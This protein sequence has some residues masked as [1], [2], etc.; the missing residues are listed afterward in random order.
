MSV[1]SLAGRIGTGLR[2]V[3]SGVKFAQTGMFASLHAELNQFGI[4]TTVLYPAYIQTNV[5]K[6]ALVGSGNEVFGNTD[7]NIRLGLSVEHC[8]DL[9]LRGIFFRDYEV[10]ICNTYVQELAAFLCGV[11]AT[12][13]RAIT[14]VNFRSQK[15][16]LLVEK[17]A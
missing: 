9:M 17:E 11:S 14:T 16:A 15:A 4:S 2:S 10:Q 6:N 7:E 12:L 3:Y 8:A 1:S 5:S 13:H